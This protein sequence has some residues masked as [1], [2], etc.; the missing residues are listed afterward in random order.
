[1]H[2]VLANVGH[3][4]ILSAPETKALARA[5]P[6][7]PWSVVH[8]WRLHRQLISLVACTLKKSAPSELKTVPAARMLDAVNGPDLVSSDALLEMAKLGDPTCRQLD[9]AAPVCEILR[10]SANSN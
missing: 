5:C 2:R 6:S 9:P 3:F 10:L 7:G 1:M 8:Q 4:D